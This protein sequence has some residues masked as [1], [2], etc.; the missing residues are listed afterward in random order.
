MH[1]LKIYGKILS[2][3]DKMLG[4]MWLKFWKK[5]EEILGIEERLDKINLINRKGKIDFFEI[6]ITTFYNKICLV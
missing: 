1:F 2:K 4:K 6:D 5:I 3:V